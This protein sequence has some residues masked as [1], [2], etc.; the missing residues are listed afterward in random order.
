MQGLAP[1]K[2]TEV[3][4]YAEHAG[5]VRCGSGRHLARGVSAVLGQVSRCRGYPG[6]SVTGSV[7]AGV[8]QALSADLTM[9]GVKN[10]IAV[11]NA[12]PGGNH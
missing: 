12:E 6:A 3:H 9:S 11:G 10:A 5:D 4:E 1:S 7:T 2:A 8:C